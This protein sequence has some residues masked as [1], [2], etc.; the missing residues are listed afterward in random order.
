MDYIYCT[1]TREKGSHLTYQ[2]RQTLERMVIENHRRPAK[3]RISK[4]KMAEMLGVHRSTISRELKRGEIT[5]RD[6][7]WK[8]YTSYCAD[9]AQD[10]IDS[11]ATAKGPSLKLGKDQLFHDFVEYW[12][13][14]KKYSPDAVI[15]KIENEGLSFETEICTKTLYNYISKGY[16][17]NLT[18]RNLPRRGKKAKRRY[19]RVR[20]SYRTRGKSID[21]R[22][23]EANERSEFGHWE[24]DCVESGRGGRSC[25]L[26]FVERQ[27]NYSLNFKLLSQSQK[28]VKMQLDRM[29]RKLGRPSFSRLF[30]SITVDNG[31]EFLGFKNLMASLFAKKKTRTEIY[32]CHPY[33]SY[34]RGSNEQMNGQIRRFIP[35][36]TDIS[37]VSKGR[38]R[39][40]TN[41]FN[42]YPKRSLEGKTSEQLFHEELAKLG[43]A[44]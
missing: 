8:E 35:K 27:T 14:E 43:I 5:Q 13:I 32:Y 36:G 44:I 18:N 37:K 34:E 4:S 26:T 23:I 31:S 25:L 19:R 10:L 38:V 1:T 42:T 21:Q 12:I 41:H 39:E 2:D 28:Q 20:K 33:S 22:P 29:E 6:I 16:F 15:M 7:M 24:M 11:N 40:I 30:K 3:E 9:V 17:L